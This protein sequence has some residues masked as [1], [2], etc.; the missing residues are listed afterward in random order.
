MPVF[1]A[2]EVA[3][4]IY[5]YPR[6]MMAILNAYLHQ[7]MYEELSGIGDELRDRG[8]RRPMM[9]VHNTGGMASCSA[10]RRSARTTAA[11]SRA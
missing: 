2:S 6:T 10:R 11:R 8:Y 3:P 1:L 5:E 4:R 9:M 7:A